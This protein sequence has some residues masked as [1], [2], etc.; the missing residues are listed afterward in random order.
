MDVMKKVPVREQ[1]SSLRGK[2]SGRA[3]LGVIQMGPVMVD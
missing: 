2:P 1:A 3:V